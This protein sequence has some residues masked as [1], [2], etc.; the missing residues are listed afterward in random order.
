MLLTSKGRSRIAGFR[1]LGQQ[2]QLGTRPT[3]PING[4]LFIRSSI[5]DVVVDSAELGGLL[6]NM[7]DATTLRGR[8]GIPLAGHTY[9]NKQTINAR[10]A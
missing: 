10:I 8:H 3:T 5:L 9:S 1:F 2:H 4:S 6:E 7:R